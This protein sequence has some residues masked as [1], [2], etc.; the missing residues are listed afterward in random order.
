MRLSHLLGLPVGGGGKKGEGAG[1]EV[2]RDDVIGFHNTWSVSVV[3]GGW[4]GET[5]DVTY[6]CGP[7]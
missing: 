4:R 7:K 2:T 6:S 3:G 5:G 1:S